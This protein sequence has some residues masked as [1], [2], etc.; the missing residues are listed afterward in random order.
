MTVI[1]QSNILGFIDSE[2]FYRLMNPNM[3]TPCDKGY[4]ESKKIVDVSCIAD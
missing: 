4:T 3:M 1:I 2:N